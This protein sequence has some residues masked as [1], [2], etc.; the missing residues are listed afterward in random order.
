[1]RSLLPHLWKKKSKRKVLSST[2][3]SSNYP[4][5]VFMSF[6][7][8]LCYAISLSREKYFYKKNEGYTSLHT[9]V[10]TA[11][12]NLQ[13]FRFLKNMSLDTYLHILEREGNT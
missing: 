8:N 6:L 12:I 3:N 11:Y 4:E 13:A 2:Q 7:S 5:Y 1:M 10:N 9:T